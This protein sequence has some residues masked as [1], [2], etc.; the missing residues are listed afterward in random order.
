MHGQFKRQIEAFA[1]KRSC[2]WLKKGCLK[3]QTES[4]L[5]SAQN[6]A[7]GTNYIKAR[8]ER[9]RESIKCRMCKEKDETVSFS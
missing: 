3:R 6:Q 2:Q 8:I 7:L 1:L 4:L 5:V 9:S